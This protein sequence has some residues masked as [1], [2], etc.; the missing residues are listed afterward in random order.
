MR[1]FLL[2]LLALFVAVGMAL[3]TLAQDSGMAHVRFAHFSPAI[4]TARVFYNGE[5]R[6]T[7]LNFR[8]VTRWAEVEPGTL[9]VAVGAT[10]AIEEAAIT[11]T[12][13]LAAGDYV[14]LA[15]IGSNNPLLSVINESFADIPE[16]NARVTILHG[17]EGAPP[18]DIL[19]NGSPVITLL[20]YPGTVVNPDGLND[21]IA[22]LD[23]PA[24]TY[25][26][27]VAAN[28]TSTTLV[29]LPGTALEAGMFYLVA[30]VGTADAPEAVVSAT[31]PSTFMVADEEEATEE[32]DATEEM[33]ATEEAEATEE[34]VVEEEPA[35][36]GT[37]IE[38]ALA[39][40]ELST[41]AAA[42][43]AA[44]PAVLETLM[45]G[46]NFT[47]FAPTNDAFEATLAD[48]DM[49]LE[50]LTAD[51]ELLT[52]VLQYHVVSG[53]INANLLRDGANLPTLAGD[54]IAVS[55]D[56][57]TVTLN[58]TVTVTEADIIATDGVIHLI[59]GVLMPPE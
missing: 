8:S 31:D 42:V 13:E 9:E 33:E 36:P 18:V 43:Q 38:T 54:T 21:G 29:D 55:V 32:A 49:T 17:I 14:T 41:L 50:D 1:K 22:S 12:V 56:G 48:M 47:I 35:T 16:G 53:T 34:E 20:G 4:A 24:G 28:G 30:A 40:P 37:L 5:I 58:D 57:D 39:N 3:P 45:S 2:V 52:R 19:A 26:L 44:D 11:T 51:P 6:Y 25:D 46:R 15:A 23:V 59:D 10:S 7:G 27:A